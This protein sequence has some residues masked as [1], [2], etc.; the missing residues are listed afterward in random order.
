MSDVKVAVVGLPRSG[1]RLIQRLLQ[2]HGFVAEVRHYG[3]QKEFRNGGVDP[4]FAVWPVRDDVAWRASCAKDLVLLPYPLGYL[5][6]MTPEMMMHAHVLPTHR[7]LAGAGITILPVT[8]ESIITAH[9]IEGMRVVA[10]CRGDESS[11]RVSGPW[12]KGWGEE[13]VDGNAKYRDAAAS[14][15]VDRGDES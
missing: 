11:M 13:I 10:F 9:E 1:N 12:W 5:G 7:W 8:Y 2:R 6:E 3:M 4:D 15:A 14:A